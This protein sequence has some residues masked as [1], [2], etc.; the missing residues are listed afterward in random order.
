MSAP[1]RQYGRE[2]VDY[3]SW[4]SNWM[5][6]LT[7]R[8]TRA[9]LEA[10]LGERRHE[11]TRAARLHLRAIQATTGM[12][13]QSQRRA[14]ARNATAAAGEAAIAIRAALE[15]H[16]LFPEHARREGAH[17]GRDA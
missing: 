8:H 9:E 10:M 4:Y 15:I 12:N 16:E 5:R 3:A 1:L 6:D 13:S 7:R 14:H 11:A 2:G 17:G